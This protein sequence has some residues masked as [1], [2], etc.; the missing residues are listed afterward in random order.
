MTTKI[1]HPKTNL[2]SGTIEECD[3]GSGSFYTVD[4]F[5]WEDW[6][7]TFEEAK[8]ELERCLENDYNGSTMEGMAQDRETEQQERFACGNY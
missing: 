3:D 4:S 2:I 8:K 6:H 7:D 1:F 5:G